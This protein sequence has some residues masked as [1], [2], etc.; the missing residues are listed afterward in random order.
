M[1]PYRPVNTQD[2]DVT[3][4]G[5]ELTT[6]AGQRAVRIVGKVDLRIAFQPDAVAAGVFLP[7][8]VPE[9]FSTH[10]GDLLKIAADSTAGTANVAYLTR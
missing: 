8:G 10:P 2:V 9:Y 4:S 6:G 3:S 5:S 1:Y 7:A